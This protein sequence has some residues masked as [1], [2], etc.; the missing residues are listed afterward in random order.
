MCGAASNRLDEYVV[1][2][3]KS[4]FIRISKCTTKLRQ[5]QSRASLI[6][7]ISLNKKK[8]KKKMKKNPN[9]GEEREAIGIICCA[10][11]WI[12]PE[13]FAGGHFGCG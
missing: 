3:K 9:G 13:V 6:R 4:L 1:L 10:R 7:D 11:D 12:L 8:K 2:R 5:I